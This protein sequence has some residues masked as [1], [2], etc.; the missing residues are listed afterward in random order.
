LEQNQR[1]KLVASL[2][3]CLNPLQKEIPATYLRDIEVY[4]DAIIVTK[5][6]SGF[7]G[8]FHRETCCVAELYLGLLWRRVATPD[9]A[10]VN[11]VFTEQEG[12]VPSVRQLI[13]V[14]DARW[15]FRFSEYVERDV[16]EKKHMILDAL[17]SALL[18][19]AEERKWDASSLE[20]CR[21]EVICRNLSY[22][23][24]SKKS[25][26]SP[27]PKYRA[28]VGFRYGLR[29]VDFFVVIF[30]RR[31]REIGNKPLGA[32][33]PEMGVAHE[34]LKG[35]GKW[36]RGKAFRFLPAGYHIRLPKSG[37]WEVDV[38]DLLA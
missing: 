7:V 28:K 6:P 19:I 15:L 5:V 11:L 24:L 3:V 25:W 26:L 20:E 10:K 12:F 13:D 30:D 32:V 27:N 34:V 23:G 16:A 1:E 33:V 4:A 21:A 8:W 37:S 18:W 9:T 35:T 2:F 22:E 17:H 14:A 36:I 38:S 31:G 29:A